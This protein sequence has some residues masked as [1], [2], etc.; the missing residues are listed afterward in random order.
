MS[1][2]VCFPRFPPSSNT[3]RLENDGF[4]LVPRR[5]NYP[6]R[7]SFGTIKE[8]GRSCGADVCLMARVPCSQP[9]TGTWLLPGLRQRCGNENGGRRNAWVTL[10][11]GEASKRPRRDKGASRLWQHR[12]PN[13]SRAPN[14]PHPVSPIHAKSGISVCAGAGD[15]TSS[16]RGRESSTLIESQTSGSKA[17]FY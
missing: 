6:N 15:P 7:E 5:V 16:F 2:S 1:K 12:D 10:V 13:S 8:V 3:Q 9:R 4:I 11:R 14:Q 17:I